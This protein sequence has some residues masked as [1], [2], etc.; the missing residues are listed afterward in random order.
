[1]AFGGCF[2]SSRWCKSYTCLFT[3]LLDV[4]SI[5]IPICNDATLHLLASTTVTHLI[6]QIQ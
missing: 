5:D 4:L 3:L 2:C 1:M 6:S